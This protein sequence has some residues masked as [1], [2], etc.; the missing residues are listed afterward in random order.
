MAESKLGYRV[1]ALAIYLLLSNR[2]SMSSL[3]FAR[4]LGVSRKTA[5]FLG[6]RIRESWTEQSPLM[7]GPV[8]VDETYIGG[9]EKNKHW[10]KK[11][12]AGRGPVGKIPLVE[13]DDGTYRIEKNWKPSRNGTV[14][15]LSGERLVAQADDAE[16]WIAK[17]LK[18]P[19]KGGPAG[20]L[21]V[22][23]GQATLDDVNT[24]NIQQDLMT[25]VSGEIESMTGGRTMQDVRS[26]CDGELEKFLTATGRTKTSSPLKG[27]DTSIF[28]LESEQARLT[29]LAGQLDQELKRRRELNAQFADLAN[30][31]ERRNR[32]ERLTKAEAR[33]DLARRHS[34][35]I[36]RALE[37]VRTARIETER[38]IERADD[39]E[40]RIAEATQARESLVGAKETERILEKRRQSAE[41]AL[42][43]HEKIVNER[44]RQERDALAILEKVQSVAVAVA[45]RERRK[46][47]NRN[48]SRAT[49]L[50]K[51]INGFSAAAAREAQDEAL[52]V[53]ERL[54]EELL[55]IKKT[56]DAEAPT[57][58]MNY[59]PGRDSDI[60]IDGKPLPDKSSTSIPDGAQ[61]TIPAI[62]ELAIVPGSR[63]DGSELAMKRSELDR[64][65]ATVGVESIEAGRQSANRRRRIETQIRD[66]ET[67]LKL[68]A[69]EGTAAL[70]REIASLPETE[71]ETPGLPDTQS[72]KSGH[73]NAR[74]QL[75]EARTRLAGLQQQ[76]MHH[77]TAA[78][79][80]SALVESAATRVRNAESA[81]AT[82]DDP[83][84]ALQRLRDSVVGLQLSLTSIEAK[85]HELAANAPDLDAATAVRDR[86]RSIVKQAEEDRQ[87]LE[88]SLAKLNSWIDVQSGSAVYEELADIKARLERE[89]QNREVLQFELDVLLKL[90]EALTEAHKIARDKYVAPVL[91]ELV[92]LLRYFWPEVKVQLD[93]ETALPMSLV[94]SGTEEDVDVLSGG[95]REQIALLVRLAFA[96]LLGRTGSSAPVIL[97]DG[98]VFTDDDRIEVMFDALTR[99]ARDI[100]IIV[101]SCR[102]KAFRDLGANSLEISPVTDWN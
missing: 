102:Q 3:A 79:E 95:T 73:E 98:I 17:R 59:F 32:E 55:L 10:K 83:Q 92:P 24:I 23:Q 39:L 2:K 51:E 72:A 63:S 100:Q 77:R 12:K 75:T 89:R 13:F 76:S 74:R 22:R 40:N 4:T 42:N 99:Q 90:R 70:E 65:L 61:L 20:L 28:E 91:G 37:K 69:P 18:A 15:I 82:F 45:I 27:L 5:W 57:L 85:H 14:R 62:G 26:R 53:A 25:S 81:L 60:L 52:A 58:N 66:A 87:R 21:W 101:F 29:E 67:E 34:D 35:D 46:A 48:L 96:R 84:S 47:L 64:A 71:G 16:S 43:E 8:E 78:I 6:H 68:I 33:F 50:R 31:E 1:W 49:E 56:R 19:D 7:M 11:R 41:I 88:I 54:H 80:A 38:E 44:D 30:P 93:A 86:A 97:D 36:D 9:K 94:R